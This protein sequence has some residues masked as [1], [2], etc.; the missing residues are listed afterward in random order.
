[1]E[2]DL[3]AVSADWDL[4]NEPFENDSNPSAAASRCNWSRL[5]GSRLPDST[6]RS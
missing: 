1:M 3:Q 4:S 6:S 2:T 5:S